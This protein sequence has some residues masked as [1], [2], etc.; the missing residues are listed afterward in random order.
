LAAAAARGGE[1]GG[2]YLIGGGERL[3]TF[4]DDDD[5]SPAPLFLFSKEWF[6]TTIHSNRRRWGE[7]AEGF[8]LIG[9]LS[10]TS[11]RRITVCSW[12]N[13]KKKMITK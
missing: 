12:D 7:A 6:C 13:N 9:C 2:V 8:Y 10:F 11:T 5:N 1:G 4:V 3:S